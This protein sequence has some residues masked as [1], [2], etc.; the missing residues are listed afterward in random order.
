M[1]IEIK[2]LFDATYYALVNPDLKTAGI[3]SADKLY[4]HFKNNGLRE[5]RQF[6]PFVDIQV[7]QDE[8]PDLA[9]SGLYS[10]EQLYQH[11]EKYGIQEGRKFS[12]LLDLN[13]YL[14]ENPDVNQAFGGDRELAFEHLRNQGIREGRTFS[15]LM[16]INYYL[17]QNPDVA[18]ATNNDKLAAFNH[19]IFVGRQ[20]GRRFFPNDLGILTG[21]G[22]V[23]SPTPNQPVNILKSDVVGNS[24]R[25]DYYQFSLNEL[26]DISLTVHG[27]AQKVRL[28]LIQDKNNNNFPDE[29]EE[30]FPLVADETPV[31][32][33]DLFAVAPGNYFIQVAGVEGETPYDL[34]LYA[35]PTELLTKPSR[36]GTSP[37]T[38]LNLGFL[39]ES[40][41]QRDAVNY[42]RSQ[43]FYQFQLSRTSDV[44][45]GLEGLSTDAVLQI[46]QDRNN[47][48]LVDS[49]EAIETIANPKEPV[50]LDRNGEIDFA[51]FFAWLDGTNQEVPYP[52]A[53]I[54]QNLLPGNYFVRVAQVNEPTG[55]H[56]QLDAIPAPVPAGGAGNKN[57]MSWGSLGT[58]NKNA[59]P[60]VLD[61][62]GY[63]NPYD[64]YDFF[65]EET[66]EVSLHLEGI[67]AKADLILVHDINQDGGFSGRE[68]IKFP[69]AEDG[70]DYTLNRVLGRGVYYVG[71]A[72]GTPE[73]A[74][75]L[76]AKVLSE[77]QPFDGAGNS[78]S[79]AANLGV[80]NGVQT[81]NDFVDD[82]DPEDFYRFQVETL[83]DLTLFLDEQTANGQ[84][85][86]LQDVNNNGLLDA[87][88]IIMG[89][90]SQ[91]SDREQIQRRLTPG[92]Y[93]IRVK[94]GMGPGSY[95]LWMENNPVS[96][97]PE[98]TGNG[99]A[100]AKDLGLLN[101][102]QRQEGIVTDTDPDDVYR[103]T[104]D[105]A[106][107]VTVLL[108]GLTANADIRLIQDMN[109]NGQVE[110]NEILAIAAAVG[111]TPE[112][113]SQRNLAPGNYYLWVSQTQGNTAYELN[114][115]PNDYNRD[116]GHGLVDAAAAVAT[117]IGRNHLSEPFAEVPA[118]GGTDWGLDLIGV[119]KV[120]QQGY[121]GS[122]IVVAV[123]DSGVDYTHPDLDDNIWL[124][125]DEIPGNNIDDDGN[126]FID[127]WRGWDFLDGDNDPR[128][129]DP[130]GGHGNHVAGIIAGE[131][132]SIG[133]T[134][135]APNAKIMPIRSLGIFRGEED[136][137]TGGIRYAV[138]NGADVIN[139]SLG[140]SG[141][142]SGVTEAIRY[143]NENGVVVVM[144]SGNDGLSG[145]AG[146]Q[147]LSP[148][149]FP[150]GLS[151]EVG[152]AV[153][154][155][156]QDGAIADFTNRAGHT[157]Q[158]YILAPGKDVYSSL[159]V[160]TYDFWEGT[161]MATPHISGVAA[162]ILSANPNLIP[163]QVED[164]I[165]GTANPFPV[166]ESG[167]FD[168]FDL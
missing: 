141:Q 61:F 54:A 159:L 133:V 168:T 6:S 118:L 117:A 112:Q 108:D 2:D 38:A 135:V 136:P 62:V 131:N 18:A 84:L 163:S 111:A 96:L 162:L 107:D 70:A 103:F 160:D 64:F 75:R 4:S 13:L 99:L 113:L 66:G 140:S 89:S 31:E 152:L 97:P 137:I 148:V 43:H 25:E 165:T 26:S 17:A 125:E 139:L 110:E 72:K 48:G 86:L 68:I 153:G 12:R 115:V 101:G 98:T 158:D 95:Y 9:E 22:T 44:Y 121:T 82:E 42:D 116:A 58:L 56:L 20:E 127:D 78:L 32:A 57:P 114:L 63:G 85:Y 109:N 81:R 24:D 8:N 30:I 59:N 156:K 55:Y 154:A 11:L 16:D 74:Y 35:A 147:R 157:P 33:I 29:R 46:I 134:G 146:S 88:E 106:H 51:E 129:L 1:T 50:D 37:G 93:Y 60:E 76:S 94:Q 39:R 144:A 123:V 122:E 155:V 79:Q 87:D 143:A 100:T 7:Y 67:N 65:L 167:F 92:T 104:L 71:V 132:N 14:Q 10:N 28:K 23:N 149:N 36:A 119:P 19:W 47:N 52:D 73:T 83:S 138:D 45:V 120:W 161:S 49:G 151:S 126:G 164:L 41:I 90:E 91:G 69:S 124:N 21:N 166:K 40:E 15:Q 150:A 128:D 130:V 3:T 145:I 5:G 105:A 142:L 53:V 77:N 34:N 102:W 80:L 27:L